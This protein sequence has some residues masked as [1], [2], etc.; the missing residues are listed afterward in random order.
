MNKK[1]SVVGFFLLAGVVVAIV[2]ASD[3]H[4]SSKQG[5]AKASVIQDIS[6]DV[7]VSADTGGESTSNP[8]T[9]SEEQSEE[10]NAREEAPPLLRP[11]DDVTV[12]KLQ[13]WVDSFLE[14]RRNPHF[15]KGY[16]I[17][18][19]NY[20]LLQQIR[21]GETD[22]FRFSFKDDMDITFN[23]KGVKE[24]STSWRMW[25]TSQEYPDSLAELSIGSDGS[26]LGGISIIGVGGFGFQR[27]SELSF[28][29]VYL[30]RAWAPA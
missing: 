29:L 14:S 7:N 17:V 12:A 28:Y 21:Y 16:E 10:T 11:A 4:L 6:P 22:K 26:I 20:D 19:V 30:S 18:E 9:L 24:F 13:P 2:V 27:S 25:A 23:V 3:S 15:I 8:D 5:R 1:T